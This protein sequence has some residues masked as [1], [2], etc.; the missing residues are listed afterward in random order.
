MSGAQS[1]NGTKPTRISDDPTAGRDLT[2][3]GRLV[4]T[5][6]IP[7]G[8]QAHRMPSMPTRL[9]EHGKRFHPDDEHRSRHPFGNAAAAPEVHGGGAGNS[10]PS[11]D[12]RTMGHHRALRVGTVASTQRLRLAL[13]GQTEQESL[14][15]RKQFGARR[16]RS[17]VPGS[18]GPFQGRHDGIHIVHAAT[19]SAAAGTDQGGPET[20]VGGEFFVRG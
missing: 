6:L 1:F 19:P 13:S 7:A 9:D 20:G 15:Y 16:G 4:V 14:V 2:E 18:R 8:T 11:R 17:G 10:N 3:S 12:S 5:R